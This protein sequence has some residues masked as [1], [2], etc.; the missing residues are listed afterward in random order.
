MA[1]RAPA[2]PSNRGRNPNGHDSIATDQQGEGDAWAVI[3]EG[4][5]VREPATV[6]RLNDIPKHK[7]NTV[8]QPDSLEK[9]DLRHTDGL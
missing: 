2:T 4:S 1:D 3:V 7:G 9:S 6:H 8:G 5:V